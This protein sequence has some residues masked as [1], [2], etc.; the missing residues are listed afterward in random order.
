[1]FTAQLRTVRRGAAIVVVLAWTLLGAQANAQVNVN[2]TTYHNDNL[3]TGVNLNETVLN[4]ANVNQGVFGL[5]FNCPVDGQVYAQ[6]LVMSNV[7][8]PDGST[9]NVVFVATQH[10]S[11]Y[12][13][14]ADGPDQCG[15][16]LWYHSFIDPDNGITPVPQPDLGQPP[17]ITPELGITSTPVIDPTT[18]TLY[19]VVK[20]KEVRAN[21]GECQTD[22]CRHFVQTLHALDITT[23]ADT[24][25]PTIIGD[26]VNPT[27]QSGNN[28]YRY[29]IGTCVPGIGNGHI[30]DADSNNIV[31]FNAMRE[32]ERSGLVVSNGVLYLAWASHTDTGPYHGWVMGF[33]ETTLQQIDG[34]VFNT[35]PNGGLG[36]IWMGG[37]APAVD[38]VGNIYFSTGNGTF[39]INDADFCTHHGPPDNIGPCNPAYGDSVVKLSTDGGLSFVDFFTPFNQRALDDTDA[40]LASGGVLLVPDTLADPHPNVLITAGKEGKIYTVDRD[41]PGMYRRCDVPPEMCDDVVAFTPSH[42]VAGQA[43][44]TPAYLNTGPG[45]DRRVY[46]VGSGDHLKVFSLGDDGK[47]TMVAQ[48]TQNFT[49]GNTKG[50]TVSISGR[51]A[52]DGTVFNAI[53]W[54]TQA[55]GGTSEVGILRAYDALASGT[56]TELY[57]SNQAGQRDE[58]GVGMKFSVPTVANGKVYVGTG[59]GP[60]NTPCAATMGCLDVFGLFPQ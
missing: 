29:I 27:G 48:G 14:D 25:P 24:L 49:G 32:H 7:S 56:L 41:D 50:A 57:D 20:T 5:L 52:D 15:D 43:A 13:F 51:I 22:S 2:V 54:A 59:S 16:P 42:T 38:P 40:D 36:G 33:D 18:G 45:L 23:G 47:L 21:T 26:T 4:P 58:L 55:G 10:D 6:P 1:M 11:V 8:F 12:A 28:A 60:A 53:A 31:C 35:S 37:G 44:D 30:V 3:R 9:H 46:Y 34:A 19:V 39:A 17:D